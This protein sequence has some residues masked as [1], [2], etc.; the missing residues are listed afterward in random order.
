[1][2]TNS[3]SSARKDFI[4]SHLRSQLNKLENVLGSME[5][6]DINCTYADESLKEIE[7]NL[8]QIRR[9]CADN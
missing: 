8:R 1:M 9:L 3:I 2:R 5:E 4:A 7:K 6:D